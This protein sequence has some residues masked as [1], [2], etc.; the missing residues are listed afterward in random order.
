M[1]R[2]SI[3]TR[4]TCLASALKHHLARLGTEVQVGG[5]EGQSTYIRLQLL[6][7]P[8]CAISSCGREVSNVLPAT[9]TRQVHCPMCSSVQM[10]FPNFVSL[11]PSFSF[12]SPILRWMVSPSYKYAYT[13]RLISSGSRAKRVL[14]HWKLVRAS[15][16]GSGMEVKLIADFL[17]FSNCEF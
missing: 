6:I 11:L 16:S 17:G 15:S 13:I 1:R 4:S 5:N 3:C 7:R 10:K 9:T 14:C 2:G 12:F 8:N